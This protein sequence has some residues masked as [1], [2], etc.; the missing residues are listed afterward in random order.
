LYLETF[1]REHFTSAKSLIVLLLYS[2]KFKNTSNK[3]ERSTCIINYKPL[4]LFFFIRSFP[5]Y[6]M[7]IAFATG[8]SFVQ[9]ALVSLALLPKFISTQQ[10]SDV[11]SYASTVIQSKVVYVISG[12]N[13][14]IRTDTTTQFEF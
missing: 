14:R 5:L 11:R 8:Q 2:P 9:L 7:R 4:F 10:A 3:N 6:I 13:V 12:S 1:H